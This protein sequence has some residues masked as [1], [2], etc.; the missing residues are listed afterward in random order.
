[1]RTS[2]SGAFHVIQATTTQYVVQ[3]G[4]NESL[5]ISTKTHLLLKAYH[6]VLADVFN[7]SHQGS[8]KSF[9]DML[10][11][12]RFLKS[13]S[14]HHQWIFFHPMH[15]ILFIYTKCC[16]RYRLKVRHQNSL[17][18]HAHVV[19]YQCLYHICIATHWFIEV[20]DPTT[21]PTHYPYSH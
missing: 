3:Q 20:L 1:M 11:K 5:R 9:G 10:L 12:C 17:C 14:E 4:Q 2:F 19:P 7:Y 6:L 13:V 18:I 15:V 8:V 16:R 21:N